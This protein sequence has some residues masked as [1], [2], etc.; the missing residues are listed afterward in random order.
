MATLID[1]IATKRGMT[2]LAVM[3]M[4]PGEWALEVSVLRGAD[5]EKARGIGESIPL[6][7]DLTVEAIAAVIAQESYMRS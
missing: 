7:K 4:S 3:R 1:R 5:E 2:C 6:G